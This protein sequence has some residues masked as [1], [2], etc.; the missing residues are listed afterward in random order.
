[1]VLRNVGV[2]PQI[3]TASQ[4][5]RYRPESSPSRKHQTSLQRDRLKE[6]QIT[7]FNQHNYVTDI[8]N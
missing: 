4:P 2:L 6:N 3:Y 5:Q 1:M 7:S 8:R